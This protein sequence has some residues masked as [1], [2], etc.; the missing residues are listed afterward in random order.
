M[1]NCQNTLGA[2][3]VEHNGFLFIKQEGKEIAV[4]YCPFC[5][6][7]AENAAYNDVQEEPSTNWRMK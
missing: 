7:K 5:G 1:H 3:C 4:N 6:T 2:K